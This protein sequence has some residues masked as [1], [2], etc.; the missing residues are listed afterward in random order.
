MRTMTLFST[1]FAKRCTA[2]LALLVWVFMFF[3]GVANACLLERGTVH[4]GATGSGVSVV[5]P[6][7]AA[8]ELHG[9]EAHGDDS[10]ATASRK[11][12]LK[13]CDDGS[14]SLPKAPTGIDAADPGV[15][16][17]FALAWLEGASAALPSGRGL[18]PVPTDTGPPIRV[19]FARLAL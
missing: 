19:R 9:G 3:S 14:K 15:A 16:I 8:H 2:G 4:D 1:I 11:S 18:A 10:A 13:A 12:C 5:P 7:R 6:M 17:L